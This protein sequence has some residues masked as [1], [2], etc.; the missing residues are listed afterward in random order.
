[1]ASGGAE[2]SLG[3]IASRG[4]SSSTEAGRATKENVLNNFLVQQQQSDEFADWPTTAAGLAEEQANDVRLWER[5]AYYLTYLKAG[6]TWA[7]MLGTV[8]SYLRGAA[9]IVASTHA[10]PGNNLAKIE[11]KN[12]WLSKIGLNIE[13]IAMDRSLE[14]GVPVRMLIL[15]ILANVSIDHHQILFLFTALHSR[16]KYFC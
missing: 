6:A 15:A 14:S 10:K 7:F 8:I 13:R 9:H 1:M 2:D 4:S 11:A 3:S 12:S 5:F 16:T